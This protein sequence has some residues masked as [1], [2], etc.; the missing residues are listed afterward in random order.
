[1]NR[2]K[3][4]HLVRHGQALHNVR[5]EPARAAGC[6]FEEFLQLMREDDAVDASLTSEGIRQAKQ[7]SE[8]S[9]T[10]TPELCVVS[11]LS[12]AIDTSLI[13][14]GHNVPYV[15]LESL[16]ERNGMLLNGQ[17]L[18]K[19]D[20]TSKY[21]N[22]NFENIKP[23]KDISWYHF[24]SDALETPEACSLRAYD[25]L[26]WVLDRPET[27]IAITAH[28]GL[29]HQLT[30]GL[31]KLVICDAG[32]S[33]RFHNCELR[34]VKMTWTMNSQQNDE[35]C[36]GTSQQMGE[37]TSESYESGRVIIKLELVGESSV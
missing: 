23:G 33:K 25:S 24:G 20:L 14:F 27:E 9:K 8:L 22:I 26:L 5:A 21:P 37:N 19:E 12:R 2:S 7:V 1:M 32:T 3:I 28:G 15:C 34:T 18:M 30:T 11:P 4:I 17:R 29:F 36:N 31:P 35:I 6:S 10:L 13:V 16:R